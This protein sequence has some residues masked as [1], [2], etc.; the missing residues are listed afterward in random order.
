[1]CV[2][3]GEMDFSSRSLSSGFS[4]DK[5]FIYVAE[6]AETSSRSLAMAASP[7]DTFPK[8]LMANDS[9]SPCVLPSRFLPKKNIDENTEFLAN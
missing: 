8:A 5:S 6:K 7:L 4:P 2:V 1:M 3:C 9:T